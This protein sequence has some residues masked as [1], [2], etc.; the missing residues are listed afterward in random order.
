MVLKL[1]WEEASNS[2]DT[3]RVNGHTSCNLPKL[4]Q[5]HLSASGVRRLL[6]TWDGRRVHLRECAISSS[7]VSI[8]FFFGWADDPPLQGSGNLKCDR[9][10]EASPILIDSRG[11]MPTSKYFHIIII[12]LI[13][14]CYFK[15]DY[16]VT[17]RFRCL[18][19]MLYL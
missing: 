17:I 13:F 3:H 16:A 11:S 10:Q 2:S 1:L 14:E 9:L 7:L 15:S 8:V 19:K 4:A 12:P 5:Y 6:S 18:K